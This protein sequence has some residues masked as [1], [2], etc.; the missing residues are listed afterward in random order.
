MSFLFGISVGI[1]LGLIFGIIVGIMLEIIIESLKK[2]T[3]IWLKNK[4]FRKG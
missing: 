1:C 3:Q 2:N 4:I